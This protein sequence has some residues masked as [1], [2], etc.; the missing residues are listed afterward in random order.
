MTKY[1]QS[2]STKKTPQF[3]PVPGSAQ[4]PNSAGGYAFQVD[5]WDRLRRFLILGSEG[6]S[7]YAGERKLTY[8]NADCVLECIRADGVRAVEEISDISYEGRAPKNDPAIFALAMASALGDKPTRIRAFTELPRVARTGT[9]LFLWS[10]YRKQFGGWGRGTRRAIREWLER[11]ANQLAYQM[12][13]Y[14]QREGWTFRDI[15]RLG[16]PTP[17]T[18][19]HESLYGW[20]TGGELPEMP[21]LAPTDATK[22]EVLIHGFERMQVATSKAEV[23]SALQHNSALPWETVP[24]K[25]LSEPAVWAVLLDGGN[26]PTG[27]MLRN[28]GRMTSNGLLKTMSRA[29]SEVVKRLIDP[30][31]IKSARIHPLSVLVALKTYEQGHGARGSLSWTPVTEVVDA[32]DECFYL[33]FGN[34]EPT[35]KRTMLALDISGSMSWGEI[36]GMPGITPRV[37]SAAMALVTAR[38]EPYYAI[39]AFTADRG[40]AGRGISEVPISDHQRL[41]DVLRI[42]NSMHW[43]GTDC[44]LPMLHALREGLEIDTF[45]IYTDSET[46]AGDVHPTQALKQYRRK[47]GIPAKLVVV[48]MVSS[49]FSIADPNDGGMLDVIGF[50]TAAP[51]VISD[52]SRR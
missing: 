46:W 28:L 4:V 45:V 42:V 32:L 18:I 34:V 10:Q 20:A 26:L 43:G 52:F 21:T 36:A 13:K 8:E 9:H 37:G 31:R 17:S 12:V 38:T 30:D 11:P 2:Y 24:T 27:A 19:G 25:F 51:N 16:H 35:N 14:R 41:D 33:A 29:T 22:A 1:L 40:R 47:T 3:E 5:K 44:A 6:G 49:G 23:I 39:T 7:Y 50:D 48:G 15:L